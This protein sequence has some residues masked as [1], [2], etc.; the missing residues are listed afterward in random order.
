MKYLITAYCILIFSVA[1]AQVSKYS[2]EFLAIGVGA[3]AHGMS[4]AVT[5]SNID[6]YST[7][8]NPAALTELKFDRNLAV[9]H[10]EYFAGIAK[11][12]FGAFVAQLD[13]NS[14]AGL[15]FIRFAVDDIPN[16]SELIDSEGNIH[17]DKIKSFSANDLAIIL[18]YARKLKKEGLSLGGN[19]KIIKRNVGDFAKSWGFGIDFSARYAFKNWM[20]GANLRDVTSTFNAWSY[21]LSDEMKEVFTLTGNEIPKNTL[22]I[23]M[24]RL[25]L[26]ACYNF[27][28]NK[29]LNLK[30][31]FDFDITS[32]GKRNVLIQAKP[33]SIDPHVGLEL[34]FKNIVFVR[35]GIGNIQNETDID[36]K[37]IKT[38]QPNIGLGLIIKDFINI[39]YAFTDIGNNSLA[40]YS[41]VF[42]IS[43]SFNRKK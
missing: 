34:G 8:W 36:G 22:E 21:S 2:N 29:A 3:R 27:K 16:T 42:S 32:D 17:Y 11:Y 41:H 24:P 30:T 40:L 39:D 1:T 6:I 20:F 14:F 37:T 23:T 38:F 31:E 28:I 9:M 35:G 15:S 26:G 13:K 25:V 43:Y 33:L 18:S 7:Y 5:A 10:S 19:V 4:G 12:D